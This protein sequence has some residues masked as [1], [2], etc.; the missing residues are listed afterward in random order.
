MVYRQ[1]RLHTDS[2]REINENIFAANLA[3]DLLPVFAEE[4]LDVRSGATSAAAAT[5]DGKAAVTPPAAADGKSPVSPRSPLSPLGSKSSLL[6]SPSSSKAKV[7]YRKDSDDEE[8]FPPPP[9]PEDGRGHGAGAKPTGAAGGDVKSAAGA[10]AGGGQLSG[11][12]LVAARMSELDLLFQSM[13]G[14]AALLQRLFKARQHKTLQQLEKRFLPV[15]S[16]PSPPIS[17]LP[18]QTGHTH[19]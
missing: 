18:P 10:G 16:C 7:K 19:D 8:D 6:S 13:P 3:L 2:E 17:P 14:I 5:T 12:D 1:L 15:R 4:Y 11:E 9:P